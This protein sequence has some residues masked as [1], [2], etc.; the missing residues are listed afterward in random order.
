MNRTSFRSIAGIVAVLPLFAC[1]ESD[2][3][4]GFRISKIEFDGET[5]LTLSFTESLV[6]PTQVNPNDFRISLGRTYLFPV[7]GQVYEGRY[8]ADPG[9]A[10]N[11]YGYGYGYSNLT[12]T[13][14]SVGPSKS[15]LV[16][17]TSSTLAAACDQ[18]AE[19]TAEFGKYIDGYPGAKFDMGLFLHYAAGDIPI[20]AESGDLLANV[21]PLWVTTGKTFAQLPNYGFVNPLRIPCR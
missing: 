19:Y 21:I 10:S 9:Y 18:I 16:L 7:D 4:E 14:L 13:S 11:N 15:Q 5:T 6:D 17:E 1:H 8:Y 12:I 3:D 2:E 20:E